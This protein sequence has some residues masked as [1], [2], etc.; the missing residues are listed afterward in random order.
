[1]ESGHSKVRG[2]LTQSAGE[3]SN[4]TGDSKFQRLNL[5]AMSL[6]WPAICQISRSIPHVEAKSD[7]RSR[8]NDSGWAVEKTH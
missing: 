2:N 8:N 3:K 6:S 4:G 7:S 5:S 1:M